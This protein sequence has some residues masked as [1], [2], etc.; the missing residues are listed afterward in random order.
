MTICIQ[1]RSLYHTELDHAE[2]KYDNSNPIALIGFERLD[3]SD[4]TPKLTSMFL[5]RPSHINETS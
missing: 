2:L 5:S 1:F 3:K 4:T